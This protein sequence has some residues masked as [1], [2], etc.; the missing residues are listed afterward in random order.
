V[1]GTEVARTKIDETPIEFTTSLT[2]D[3]RFF[4]VLTNTGLIY[5]Y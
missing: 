3:E 1:L 2:G 5:V 4:G